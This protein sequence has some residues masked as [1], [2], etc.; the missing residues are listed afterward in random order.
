MYHQLLKQCAV[1]EN[2]GV[3]CIGFED[4]VVKGTGLYDVDRQAKQ[5]APGRRAAEQKGIPFFINT[6]TNVFFEN[7]ADLEEALR[8]EKAY[9]AAGATGFFVPA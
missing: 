3:V 5:I 9:A 2:L 4:R 7:S 8:R 6:R 1:F